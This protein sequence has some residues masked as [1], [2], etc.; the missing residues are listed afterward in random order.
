MQTAHMNIQRLIV[1]IAAL[2]LSSCGDNKNSRVLHGST[3][4]TT[5]SVK[6]GSQPTGGSASLQKA[7][8]ARLVII[9]Q[10]MS[11]YDPNSEL[12]TFNQSKSTDWHAVSPELATVINAAL[13][14][15]RLSDG[16]FDPTIGPLVNLWGFGPEHSDD[17]IPSSAAI[18]AATAKTGY[19]QLE[20]RSQPLS[21]RKRNPELYIDLSAIAKGYGV[22]E[23]ATLVERHGV[24]DYLAEIGGELRGNGKSSKG[25][26]WR[27]GI[28][29]P[30]PGERTATNVIELNNKAIATSGDYRNYFEK[31][32]RRF[33]HTI[34]PKTGQPITHTLASVSVVSSSTML[35][36]GWATTLMVLGPEKGLALANEQ[37][38]A[39]L[40][41]VKTDTGFIER[42]SQL[43]QPGAIANP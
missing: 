41:L 31:N 8:E 16:M 7:I 6:L 9:N 43:M 2:L 17:N 14:L 5:W 11:T 28:E 10:Q 21:L 39:V 1:V 23:I 42:R 25:A 38:L 19:Q 32:G 36:D 24:T 26:P 37:K 12:S 29:K 13:T 18:A 27:I 20:L 34:N 22:D 35:S 3:M 40:M 15:S 4:G 33:S 30:V